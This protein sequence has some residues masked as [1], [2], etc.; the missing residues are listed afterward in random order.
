MKYYIVSSQNTWKVYM[1]LHSM[2]LL[3]TVT[4][5]LPHP[6]Q[7]R[8]VKMFARNLSNFIILTFTIFLLANWFVNTKRHAN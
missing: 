7:S 5:L 3:P 2:Q 1:P 4:F 6:C 8:F